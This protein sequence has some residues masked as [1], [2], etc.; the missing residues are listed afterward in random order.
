MI[1]A[2]RPLPELEA[3]VKLTVPLPVPELPEVI[4]ANA[5]SELAV[6][7]QV[8]CDALIANVPVPPGVGIALEVEES[9][10]KQ[11]FGGSCVIAKAEPPAKIE[12][13]TIDPTRGPPVFAVTE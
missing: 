12:A 10:K 8:G 11:L 13:T 2:V 9:V 7:A 6:H 3:T 5:E 4:V 1:F